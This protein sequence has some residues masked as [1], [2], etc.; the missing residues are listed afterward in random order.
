MSFSTA[1]AALGADCG[2]T[3]SGRGEGRLRPASD[4]GRVAVMLAAAAAPTTVGGI[5]GRNV[6][7]VDF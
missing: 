1:E 3:G 5:I 6:G 2:L 4:A 7:H